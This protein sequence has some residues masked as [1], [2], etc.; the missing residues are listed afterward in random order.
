MKVE[1]K[2]LS[3]FISGEWGYRVVA[4]DETDH[5]RRYYASRRFESKDAAESYKAVI[6]KRYANEIE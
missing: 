3:P 5:G 2:K 4:Y 6:E 1:I